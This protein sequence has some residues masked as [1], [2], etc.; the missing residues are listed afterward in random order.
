M[1]EFERVIA[2]EYFETANTALKKKLPMAAS[3]KTFEELPQDEVE[4]C[5]VLGMEFIKEIE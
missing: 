2:R 3:Q 1:S 5:A 4:I